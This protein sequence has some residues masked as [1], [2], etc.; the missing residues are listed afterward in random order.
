MT[1]R[2]PNCVAEAIHLPHFPFFNFKRASSSGGTPAP[3]T[4]NGIFSQS[5]FFTSYGGCPRNPP[6][7]PGTPCKNGADAPDV[8][9]LP[10][11]RVYVA[12]HTKVDITNPRRLH[13]RGIRMFPGRVESQSALAGHTRTGIKTPCRVCIV[14]A[15][16]V[17]GCVESH[18]VLVTP[19]VS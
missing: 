2:L 18:P 8:F 5:H 19:N 14:D 12:G 17:L 1:S 4:Q 11:S 9:G 7:P 16:D 3:E 15:L 13:D 10:E 6:E